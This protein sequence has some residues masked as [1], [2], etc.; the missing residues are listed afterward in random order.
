MFAIKL[1]KM[2]TDSPKYSDIV[3]TAR[4]LFWKHGI[5]RVSIEEICREAKVSKM[6]FYRFFP[7]KTELGKT[8]IDNI[9]DES[10]EKYRNLMKQDI[11]FEEKIRKQ[12][13]LKFEGLNEISA[14]FIKDIFSNQK[15]GIHTH[16]Q[17]RTDEFVEEVKNDYAKAQKEGFIRKDLNLDFMFYFSTKSTDL[18]T[19]PKF[20]E[21]YD[22][23]QDLLMEYA[24]L[25][26]Y[27]IF[28]CKNNKSE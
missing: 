22:S 8:I 2:S 1:K 5:S 27:G 18:L 3:I 19:D 28:P 9:M 25:V 4:K 24:N 6:T 15:L 21:I 23:M 10:I 16:W 7:N 13:L 14:E 12:L 26:F 17:N 20:L 11:P